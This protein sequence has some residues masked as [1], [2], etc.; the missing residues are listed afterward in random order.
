MSETA[1][2][3]MQEMEEF[4]QEKVFGQQPRSVSEAVEEEPQEAPAEDQEPVVED[5]PPEVPPRPPAPPAPEEPAEEEAEEGEEPAEVQD[6]N[7]AWA[8]QKYGDSPEM[9]A[10]AARDMELYITRLNQ[11]KKDAEALA[12]QWAEYAETVESQSRRTNVMPLSASEEEWVGD[13]ISNPLEYAR[14]AAFSG[15]IPL[16]N[17]V[18]NQVAEENPGLAARVGTQV[19]MELRSYADME[20]QSRVAQANPPMEAGLTQSFQRL[21]LDINAH[22]PAMSDKIGQL[23]EYHPYVQAIMNGD[24]GQRD[25]ALQAVFDLAQ[26]TTARPVSQA[27]AQENEMRREAAVVQTG[28]ISPAQ[29]APKQPPLLADMK[30]EWRRAGQWQDD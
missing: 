28:G 20:E 7:V 15:N 5:A 19:Q 29:A 21:G 12:G 9:W 14:N 27:V 26:T 24:D 22:G 23:G 25:L 2:T 17:A 30:E 10:K 4:L 13:S 16:Y 6:V 8:K 18:I 3:S 1:D 11:E